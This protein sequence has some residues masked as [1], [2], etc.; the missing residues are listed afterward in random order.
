[1][2][3]DYIEYA[4]SKERYQPSGVT[5]MRVGVLRGSEQE[6]EYQSKMG[7]PMG[8]HNTRVENGRDIVECF[9]RVLEGQ[10]T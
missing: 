8:Q 3:H 1:M 2:P 9:L 10:Q 6:R 7:V 5:N 4:V